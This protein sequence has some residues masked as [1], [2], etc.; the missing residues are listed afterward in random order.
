MY[1][2]KLTINDVD[3]DFGNENGV[4]ISTI[5]G[6]TGISANI[7]TS[8]NSIGIGEALTGGTIAGLNIVIRGL[9]LDNNT[10]QRTALQNCAVPLGTGVLTI[11]DKPSNTWI[12]YRK[13]DVVVKNAPEFSQEKH[14]KF[15][16]TLFAPVPVFTEP[17]DRFVFI[18]S[19][20]T[21]ITIEGQVAADY[22]FRLTATRAGIT[23]YQLIIDADTVSEKKLLLDFSLFNAA[24]LAINSVVEFARKDGVLSLTVNGEDATQ[25]IDIDSTLWVLPLGTHTI[26]HAPPYMIG[27]LHWYNSYTGVILSGN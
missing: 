21:P 8:L 15:S 22:R 19:S 2:A 13:I 24:G 16:L 11:Y 6:L 25:C 7:E 17:A 26:K 1:K 10:T 5:E 20:E 3:F 9:M 23:T 27:D 14:S 4:Y 12:E 18:T